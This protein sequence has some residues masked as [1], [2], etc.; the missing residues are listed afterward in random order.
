MEKF[1]LIKT[2]QEKQDT[3]KGVV[4][5]VELHEYK[6][7]VF[8]F[9]FENSNGTPCGY[10]YKHSVSVFNQQQDEWKRL[11]DKDDIKAFATQ[12]ID[13]VNYYGNGAQLMRGARAFMEACKGFV[14][15]IYGK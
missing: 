2:L 4:A 13:C 3:Q 7:K 6:G 8:K 15:A 11:G 9:T 14:A 12:P 1:K 5:L 10:D